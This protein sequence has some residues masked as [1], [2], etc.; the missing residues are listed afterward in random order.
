MVIAGAVL[1]AGIVVYSYLGGFNSPE[2]SV[3]EVEPF[4]V[5]GYPFKGKLNDPLFAES[6]RKSD[7]LVDNKQLKGLVTGVFYN[8]PEQQ[9]DTVSTF[10]GVLSE[11][12]EVQGLEQ[13]SFNP[14]KVVQATIK[15]KYMVMPINIYP[16]ITQFAEE[17][18]IKLS[19]KSF[20]IYES[21]DF[22]K[23]WIPAE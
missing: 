17:N 7:S 18:N 20:E 1:I 19:A 21:D 11:S 15:A 10:V 6:F 9:D 2:I 4:K 8:Q 5:Y 14:G 16:K 22:L 12:S 23:V 13:R 3:I